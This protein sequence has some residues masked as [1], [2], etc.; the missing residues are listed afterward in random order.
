[1]QPPVGKIVAAS[2]QLVAD[3]V[4]T[5]DAASCVLRDEPIPE[6]RAEIEPV[7]QVLRLNEDICI[8]QEAGQSGIPTSRPILLNV[9][10]FDTPSMRKASR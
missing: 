10:V 5:G 7:V 9:S 4:D 6:G 8:E 2:L 1:M 3:L